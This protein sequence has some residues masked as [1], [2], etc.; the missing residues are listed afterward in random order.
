[1]LPVLERLKMRFKKGDLVEY[2]AEYEITAIQGNP[3]SVSNGDLGVFLGFKTASLI[4]VK[5]QTLLRPHVLFTHQVD[6][7]SK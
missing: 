6:K 4:L 5:F 7:I 2:N 3:G 1:M